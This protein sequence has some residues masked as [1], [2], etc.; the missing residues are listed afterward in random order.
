[1][2]FARLLVLLITGIHFSQLLNA[3]STPT[4]SPQIQRPKAP[5]RLIIRAD[6]MGMSHATNQACI[7]AYTEGIARSV[8]I[9]VPTPWFLEAVQLLKE[10]PDYD[11][12]I[13]LVLNAEWS[14]LKWRPLTSAK[15]LTDSNGYFFPTPWKGSPD[16]PSLHDHQ[17][18]FTEAATELRAQIEMAKKNLPRISHLSTHMGFEDSNPALKKIVEELSVEYQLPLLKKPA[19]ES[20][21]GNP[22]TAAAFIEQLSKL[23]PG[24][25]YLLVTH[26]CFDTPEMETVFTPTDTNVG[27]ARAADLSM[28]TNKRLIRLLKR[29]N[30]DLISIHDYL[31]SSY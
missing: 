31:N 28:I 1:M 5:I 9:M 16:F 24:K 6:D 2:K 26:P 3:Q 22:K 14:N 19:I 7:A 17:P 15:S 11:V 27:A 23:Q 10:Q 25:T 21:P 29:Y 8:E 4:Q 20:F 30:I 13:H 12:G 18:D